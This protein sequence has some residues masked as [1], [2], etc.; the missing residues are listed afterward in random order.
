MINNLTDVHCHIIPNVDDGS[1]DLKTSIE[2]INMLKNQGAQRIIL[3]PHYYSDSLS[4]SDFLA[5][6]NTTFEKLN[7]EAKIAIENCPKL[8]P[9][10]EF[11]ITKYIFSNENIDD[12][13]IGSKKH[14]LVEHPF[15]CS[16]GKST[17]ETLDNLCCDYNVVPILA[18]IE[19]YHALMKSEKLL[20]EYIDMGCLVQVN[21]SSFANEKHSVKK[22]LFKLLDKGKIHLVGSDSHNLTSRPPDFSLGAEEIR[23]KFGRSAISELMQNA[24]MITK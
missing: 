19:R 20:D 16:F 15:E 2:M 6:R 7:Q 23:K 11:F 9:A 12:I 4:Y 3:T 8:I 17:I 14:I 1:K 22:Q 5:K 18:H 13:T 24:E 10:A 21:I